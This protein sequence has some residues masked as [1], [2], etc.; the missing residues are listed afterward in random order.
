MFNFIASSWVDNEEDLPLLYTFSYYTTNAAEGKLLKETSLDYVESFLGQGDAQRGN[1]VSIV[2]V[3]SDRLGYGARTKQDITVD[4]LVITN[5][6]QALLFFSNLLCKCQLD[7]MYSSKLCLFLCHSA[8][9]DSLRVYIDALGSSLNTVD[10]Q[11]APDCRDLRRLNCSTTTNTCGSCLPAYAVG[12]HGHS[13]SQCLATDGSLR[14]FEMFRESKECPGGCSG[15]GTCVH[16]NWYGDVI[17]SCDPMDTSCRAI[18]NCSPGFFSADCSRNGT[19][20]NTSLVLREASCNSSYN[21]LALDDITS[22]SLKNYALSVIRLIGDTTQVTDIGYRLCSSLLFDIVEQKPELA[23]ADENLGVVIEAISAILGRGRGMPDEVYDRVVQTLGTLNAYRQATMGPGETPVEIYTANIRYYTSVTYLG[24]LDL[25]TRWVVAQS[26]L[27]KNLGLSASSVIITNDQSLNNSVPNT[28]TIVGI[29]LWEILINTGQ[30][31]EGTNS[32]LLQLETRLI[33][34]ELDGVPATNITS[35]LYNH[36]DVTYSDDVA[37]KIRRGTVSCYQTDSEQPYEI[38][39]I[40]QYNNEGDTFELPITCPG[41]NSVYVNYVC[42]YEYDTPECALWDSVQSEYVSTDRCQMIEYSEKSTTCLCDGSPNALNDKRRLQLSSIES[43]DYDFFAKKVVVKVPFQIEIDDFTPYDLKDS[44]NVIIFIVAL[45]FSF[46]AVLGGTYLLG[47]QG[48]AHL[49]NKYAM[50]TPDVVANTYTQI[51]NLASHI[52]CHE[53][54]HSDVYS[55]YGRALLLHSPHMSIFRWK[56]AFN[57]KINVELFEKWM[58]LT[59][60]ALNFLFIHAVLAYEIY[61][62]DG[63]CQD[64]MQPDKCEERKSKLSIYLS[65]CEWRYDGNE[66][67][68]L[69]SPMSSV[70]EIFL[71]VLITSVTVVPLNYIWTVCV[72]AV[73][74]RFT[75]AMGVA[76]FPILAI[77]EP[78]KNGPEI[79]NSRKQNSEQAFQGSSTGYEL[80]ETKY[81]FKT[82]S[83]KGSGKGSSL[84]TTDT[85]DI[86]AM[87]IDIEHEVIY[88]LSESKALIM[89]DD[90]DDQAMTSPAMHRAY[91]KRKLQLNHNGDFKEEVWFA[92]YKHSR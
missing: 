61:D 4:P 75:N 9:P 7:S 14:M 76:N 78:Q 87:D 40:C 63:Y 92:P 12:I 37:S 89:L 18:C 82:N 51:M 17:D 27:E 28:P 84:K 86:I 22:S 43:H 3:V 31:A 41:T 34:G 62:D 74:S 52:L 56:N 16:T 49:L 88:V 25:S 85:G 19:E 53:Y 58:Q 30:D 46:L 77:D 1:L 45:S 20:M 69:R 68:A 83:T 11:S 29:S 47:R 66:Y 54:A 48:D 23:V 24:S 44:D 10:C 15:R 26:A 33:F 81:Y 39:V 72:H 36:E 73:M 90:L 32:S 57:E 13:N 59:G 38:Q 50:E 65:R 55:R 67:C 79:K 91:V 8:N 71:L 80:E 6:F 42:P 5:S 64:I 70:V 2:L 35:V 21:A 60:F